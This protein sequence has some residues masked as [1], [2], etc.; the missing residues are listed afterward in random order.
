MILN[1]V[2]KGRKEMKHISGDI[3]TFLNWFEGHCMRSK[4]VQR[5][6]GDKDLIAGVQV[7]LVFV[8]MLLYG[9]YLVL[10]VL[11]VNFKID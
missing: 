10:I 7:L 3:S 5:Y 8:V 4:F 6:L 9:L 1:E 2:D 11:L